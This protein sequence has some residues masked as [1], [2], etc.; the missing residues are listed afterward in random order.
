MKISTTVLLVGG[1]ALAGSAMGHEPVAQDTGTSS[2]S[3]KVAIDPKTRMLRAP[4]AAESAALDA[5]AKATR[6]NAKAPAA[7]N[8]YSLYLPET[9][10]EADATRIERGGMVAVK[11]TADT[12]SA[13]TVVQNADGSLSFFENGEPVQIQGA[14]VREVASE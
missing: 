12:L 4:T 5:Q 9:V 14:A 8:G 6:T 3:L 1:L 13:L 2:A 11:P 10:A 7:K